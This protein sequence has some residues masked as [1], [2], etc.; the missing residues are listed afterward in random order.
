MSYQLK[1]RRIAR[2]EYQEAAAWYEERSPGRGDDFA[3]LMLERTG[4]YVGTAIAGVINL[5]NIEKIV[6]GGLIMQAEHLVL[7]SIVRRAGELSFARSFETTQ[8]VKGELGENATAV[9][10]A[11]LSDSL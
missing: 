6:V 1:F 9:G 2:T 10:A 3:R 4:I 7:D 11:L 5:L 8:I